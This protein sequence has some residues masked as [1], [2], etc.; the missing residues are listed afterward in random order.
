MK[1]KIL[2][3]FTFFCLLFLA[4]PVMAIGPWQAGEVGN[5]PN[6]SVS[7]GGLRD[8]RGEAG[9]YIVWV[10]STNGYWLKWLFFDS[11]SGQGKMNSAI[12]ADIATLAQ[13]SADGLSYANGQNTV[14]ENQ[15][16]YLSPDG[17][18]T[19]YTVPGLGTHGMVWWLF[20]AGFGHSV[21]TANDAA[22]RYPNGAFWQ[23]N[24]VQL[25]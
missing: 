1:A 8:E 17:S 11:S 20:Y 15:W 21:A 7:N 23:Y 18:G 4:A 25:T 5:N 24:F 16:I 2:L 19:Q 9:G 14:N 3:L 10:Q 22:S 6:L 12:I 13:S